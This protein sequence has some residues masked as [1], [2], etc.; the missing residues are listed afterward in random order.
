MCFCR[1]FYLLCLWAERGRS[2]DGY[3][4]VYIYETYILTGKFMHE[5]SDTQTACP[6]GWMFA[7]TKYSNYAKY[8]NKREP[9]TTAGRQV[10]ALMA[11]ARRC[12]TYLRGLQALGAAGMCTVE[13]LS[14]TPHTFSLSLFVTL[15]LLLSTYTETDL[16]EYAQTYSCVHAYSYTQVRWG[17][18]ASA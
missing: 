4:C 7:T 8:A 9:S 10:G 15:S 6:R 5:Y 16:Y 11:G 12:R 1:C 17:G 13:M 18:K 14:L 3:I 2:G